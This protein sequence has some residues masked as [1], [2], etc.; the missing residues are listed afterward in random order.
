M[1]PASKNKI[2]RGCCGLAR[3]RT[4]NFLNKPRILRAKIEVR[5][6]FFLHKTK[7]RQSNC[8]FKTTNLIFGT[9]IP[10]LR[11]L[12]HSLFSIILDSSYLKP[13][14]R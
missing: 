1:L 12:K 11:Y 4:E 10:N 8:K 2:A 5:G 14:L 7:K 13:G 9:I 6:F 3:Y